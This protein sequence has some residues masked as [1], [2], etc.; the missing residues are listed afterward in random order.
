MFIETH[1]DNDI[2]LTFIKSANIQAY[3][4]GR[5]RS[6]VVDRDGSSGTTDD[7]YYFPFD[8]EARL[9]TEANNRKQSSQNGYTQ[10]Y[11]K[12]WDVTNKLLTL[13]LA[14]YLFKISLPDDHCAV[15]DFGAKVIA[16][17]ADT[18]A[19]SIYANVLLEDVHL[20]SGFKEYYTSI[21]RNQSDSSLPEGI[22]ETSLDLPDTTT[23]NSGSLE[24][25]RDFNNYYFSGLSF[26]TTPLSGEAITRS[27][28]QR[29]VERDGLRGITA[30]Q[31][32]VSLRLLKKSGS[33]WVI[34]EPARLP[35]V[36]HGETVDS[37]VVGDT[38][39]KD[40]LTVENHTKSK[41]VEVTDRTTTK[42]LTVTT[43]ATIKEEA[44]ETA[45]IETADINTLTGNKATYATVEGTTLVKGKELLQ[46]GYKVPTIELVKSGTEWQLKITKIGTKS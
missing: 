40:D 24:N 8:P 16:Q 9:N 2:T 12:D 19:T 22:P 20:F 31:Y 44:V 5:R 42:N 21:L 34:N 14:G 10:T 43:K 46:N 38:L 26:S 28:V 17:L 37:I 15:N 4:C 23:V 32:L 13:S 11:L 18:S 27:Y 45:D 7:Q 30:K 39:V 41:T 25:L 6:T 35:L 29:T 33:T 36:E 1:S 3:P